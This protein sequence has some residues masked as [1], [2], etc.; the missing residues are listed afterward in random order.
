M[1]IHCSKNQLLKMCDPDEYERFGLPTA[2]MQTMVT[3]LVKMDILHALWRHI[4]TK[5]ISNL[6]TESN[7]WQNQSFIISFA[8]FHSSL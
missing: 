5:P 7:E 6:F 1:G 8:L 2:N 3:G 4:N